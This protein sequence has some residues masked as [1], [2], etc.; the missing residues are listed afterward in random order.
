MPNFKLADA[1][2][3]EFAAFLLK[4]VDKPN[5]AAAPTDKAL[6]ERGQKL[7]QSSGCLN[8]HAA[9]LE[10]QFTDGVAGKDR[11]GSEGMSRRET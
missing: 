9:K 11:E 7:V 1:E 2:A 6:I 3:K 4:S 5:S 10:N 8:C